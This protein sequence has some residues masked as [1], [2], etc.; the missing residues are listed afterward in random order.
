M[1]NN[2]KISEIINSDTAVSTSDGN[3]V[4]NR[5]ETFLKQEKAVFLDF[6]GIKYLT[7]AF[8]NAALGQ[9]YS[10]EYSSEF[11][12]KHL[13]IRNVT[14]A[15]ASMFHMVVKRAK[16]YF[17]DKEGFKGSAESAIYGD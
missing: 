16:E 15:N 3:I 4:Y 8:L 5:I 14:K 9:L 1:T 6:E 7:T 13:K 12:N 2:L 11:L 10:N 17:D